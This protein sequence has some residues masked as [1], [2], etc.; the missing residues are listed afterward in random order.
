MLIREKTGKA[1][2][3]KTSEAEDQRW[4][5]QQ[6]QEE[7]EGDEEGNDQV[8]MVHRRRK[9]IPARNATWSQMMQC[10]S[11][12]YTNHITLINSTTCC[13]TP[14]P[15]TIP[16]TSDVDCYETLE[17]FPVNSNGREQPE[18]CFIPTSDVSLSP[19]QF[20]EFLPLKN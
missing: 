12:P 14:T 18:K 16:A 19:R 8:M 11:S 15:T 4:I 17:L 6:Q 20:I 5:P 10:L 3:R 2:Y 1:E 9:G 7:Q 13:I